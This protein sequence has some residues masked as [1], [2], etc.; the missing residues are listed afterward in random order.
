MMESKESEM[1]ESEDSELSF[2]TFS[3]VL[4]MECL[5]FIFLASRDGVP[6]IKTIIN[7][8]AAIIL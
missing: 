1:M 4:G 2:D 8:T 7:N 5:V 3:V 6:V